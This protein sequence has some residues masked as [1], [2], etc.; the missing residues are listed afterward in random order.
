MR[1]ESDSI[2]LATKL[3][4]IKINHITYKL[5]NYVAIVNKNKEVANT[6][7]SSC[8]FGKW[9]A[10]AEGKTLIGNLPSRD[11]INTPHKS[12]HEYVNSAVEHMKQ[13]TENSNFKE[14]LQHF[15]SSEK[16]TNELF[17]SF[18]TIEE[19]YK[20]AKQKTTETVEA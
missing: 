17:D 19:E 18:S 20:N 6:S 16:A 10:S 15:K 13:G 2:Y 1:A 11:K 8:A 14:I 9:I 7:S 4:Q 3:D 5:V 12:I